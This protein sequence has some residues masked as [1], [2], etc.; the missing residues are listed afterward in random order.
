MQDRTKVLIVDDEPVN[1]DFFDVMLSKLGFEVETAEDGEEALEKLES[2]IPD[3]IILDN[4]M[5]KLSGWQVTKLL[6]NDSQYEQFHDVPI[7]M[8]SAMDDVKD[9][10]EGFEL[11]V[12]DYITKP[13]NFSEVLARI[14]AVLRGR[15]LYNQLTRKQRKIELVDKLYA[16]F[17]EFIHELKGPLNEIER[18]TQ[19]TSVEDTEKVREFIR[20]VDEETKKVKRSIEGVEA[21]I[22]QVHQAEITD[23]NGEEALRDLEERMKQHFAGL[24]ESGDSVEEVKK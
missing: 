22:D 21:D 13:F 8:F 17:T 19:V 11:G 16:S 4:V 3:L 5:P 7:I 6:K 24:R 2:Y 9:K 14:R 15:E 1:L 20:Y 10:V 18:L 12:E 23:T